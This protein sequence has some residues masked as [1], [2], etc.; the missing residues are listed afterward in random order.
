MNSVLVSKAFNITTI[1]NSD[2]CGSCR[3]DNR[4]AE[5]VRDV[6]QNV[7]HRELRLSN[8]IVIRFMPSMM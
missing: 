2:I 6:V 7:A 5:A 8:N 1:T 3:V 4:S